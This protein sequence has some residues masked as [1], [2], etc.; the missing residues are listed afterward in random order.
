MTKKIKSS[1]IL[2]AI[3]IFFLLLVSCGS[4]RVVV[5]E[6]KNPFEV[7]ETNNEVVDTQVEFLNPEIKD[8]SPE[9]IPDVIEV[10]DDEP[11]ITKEIEVI[12]PPTYNPMAYYKKQGALNEEEQELYNCLLE[13]I[14]KLESKISIPIIEDSNSIARVFEF[15]RLDSPH[16]F[17]FPSKYK[18]IRTRVNNQLSAMEIEFSYHEI[19]DLERIDEYQKE[20]DEAVIPILSEIAVIDG[21]YNK[22]LYLYQY[23]TSNVSYKSDID[24]DYTIYGALLN[25]RAT[26]EGYAETF[27]YLLNLA[28]IKAISVVGESK[29]QA[30][31][32]NMAQLDGQWYYFDVTWDCP[33]NTSKYLPYNYFALT[34]KDI[35]RTHEI[36]YSQYLPEVN[37]TKYNY[38]IYNDLMLLSYTEKDII[39]L[40]KHSLTINP[41][42]ISFRMIDRDT[43]DKVIDNIATWVPKVFKEVGIVQNEIS[44]MTNKELNIIDIALEVD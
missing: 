33:T 40:A 22:A 3:L 20:I 12:E 2:S 34:F 13:G 6:E 8:P 39:S 25:H 27:Q 21:D 42:H 43:C 7:G 11:V 31:E 32:W 28:G 26:C 29:G 9:V 36:Y 5:E 44:Y 37:N 15:V 24:A 10:I 41:S 30:H 1:F 18:I 4:R 38:Y 23:L 16:L 35:S 19:W 17:Y 14:T